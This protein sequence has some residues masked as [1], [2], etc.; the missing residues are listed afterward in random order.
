MILVFER[1]KR[2]GLAIHSGHTRCDDG[3]TEHDITKDTGRLMQTQGC[4]RVYNEAMKT[5]VG[6]YENLIKEGKTIKCYVED[7]SGNIDDV[8]DFYCL[9]LD[10]KDKTR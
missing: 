9:D 3:S 2:D 6:V 5:L 1:P 8:F 10:F 4:V 7:Y